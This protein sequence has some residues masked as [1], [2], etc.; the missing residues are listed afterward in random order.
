MKRLAITYLALLLTSLLS[1]AQS[2]GTWRYFPAYNGISEVDS[3]SSRC[4]FVLS[5]GNLFSVNKQEGSV[6]T[7][8][9]ING[10]T[11]TGIKT[12]A[13]NATAK[14]LMLIYDNSNIDLITINGDVTNIP[15]L[16][17]KET[18][19]DKTVNHVFTKNQ[20][21]YISTGFGIMKVD[22]RKAEV[23]DT[24]NLHSSI[25]K[26]YVDDSN[27]YALCSDNSTIYAS[28]SD[29]L[30]DYKTWQPYQG[31]TAGMFADES[32]KEA[33]RQWIE[34]YIP[35][36]PR[37]G[38]IGYIKYKKG[39]LY[40]AENLGWD[41]QKPDC[42]QIYD[43]AN[44]SWTMLDNDGDAISSQTGMRFCDF[45]CVETDPLN[46]NHIMAAAHGG[47]Y[48]FLD[49][50]FVKLHTDTNS[51]MTSAIENRSYYVL[52]SAM[53]YSNDGTLWVAL[54]QALHNVNMLSLE[55]DNT[56]KDH[57]NSKW[58]H[59]NIS[60]A[61]VQKMIVD[62]DG[63]LWWVNN[64]WWKPA[65][66]GYDP[67]T[68]RSYCYTTFYNE[69]NINIAPIAVKCVAEDKDGN[70]WIGTN[71][72]PLMLEKKDK[73]SSGEVIWQQVKV[74]RNDGT[75]YADYLLAGVEINSIMIDGGNRKWF[76]TEGNGIYVIDSDNITQI[77][78]FTTTSSLLPS[79]Y[80]YTMETDPQKGDIYIGTNK[81]L[82][83]Y[84]SDA[85]EAMESLNEDNIYAYPNPVT[86]D[87]TGPITVTG[88]TFD[89]DVKI[90]TANGF[91]VAQGRSNGGSF[92]WN[93]CDASGRRVASGIYMVCI[94]TADGESGVVSKIAVVR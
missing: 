44:D 74:P 10:L 92:V 34:N 20:Y 26:C 38:D 93:S 87:Y 13:W 16:Y 77:H 31:S 73:L 25:S 17:T 23:S 22:A 64:H 5:S 33:T 61:L 36:G 91:L 84:R 27:I 48:E 29:N 35:S 54:S 47:I 46:D 51:P 50:K 6:Q 18:T 83:S 63:I 57:S 32:I 52:P 21:A 67:V 76:A 68:G 62:R 55:K 45:F 69:D 85:T 70:L 30:L 75:N 53:K 80:V 11:D 9:R 89:A 41:N 42:P 60:F 24:Y 2:V 82:C 39:K 79:N 56:W 72:G 49:G 66:C 19:L 78:N 94:S 14:V 8:D 88:L 43:I 86:P 81:G 37:Y 7:Y 3:V 71:V 59:N 12:M 65:L 1:L 40:T 15:D 4:V 28:L 58:I 90:T